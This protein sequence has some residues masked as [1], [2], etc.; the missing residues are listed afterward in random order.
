MSTTRI[1][2]SHIEEPRTRKLLEGEGEKGGERERGREG[3]R[4]KGSEVEG[5]GK[6]KRKERVRRQKVVF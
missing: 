3:R 1:A 4:W 6:E 5:D 2:M